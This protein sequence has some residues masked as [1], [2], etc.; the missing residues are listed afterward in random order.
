MS[1]LVH[2][3]RALFDDGAIVFS[4]KPL[5]VPGEQREATALLAEVFDEQRLEVAGP[6]LKLSAEAA[7]HAAEFLRQACWF[8]VH[9]GEFDD[10]LKRRLTMVV[11]GGVDDHW[12]VDLLFRHLPALH[13]R[14]VALGPDDPLAD[15]LAEV[16]RQW[17]LSG[18]LSDVGEPPTTPVHF[19]GHPGL[20]LL[21]AERWAETEKHAWLPE[22]ATFE[23]L[24]LVYHQLGRPLP[25]A[26]AQRLESAAHAGSPE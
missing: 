2:F 24:P 13:R 18:V 5:P 17:P 1:S 23:F 20:Q 19:G 7:L 10:E 14:A 15:R 4:A 25:A 8:L 16:L 6:P 11:P 12:S 22:G 3:L 9:R 26:V 21:Y